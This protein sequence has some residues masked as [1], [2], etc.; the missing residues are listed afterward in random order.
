MPDSDVQATY[1]TGTVA[2]AVR[3]S[4]H[5][6]AVS[7]ELQDA[8][9]RFEDLLSE[10]PDDAQSV[11]MQT[12]WLEDAKGRYEQRKR[13][14]ADLSQRLLALD[15]DV[16]K[17]H[18]SVAALQ[19]SLAQLKQEQLA[20][21]ASAVGELRAAIYTLQQW[22]GSYVE[23]NVVVSPPD[24]GVLDKRLEELKLYVRGPLHEAIDNLVVACAKVEVSEAKRLLVG[25]DNDHHHFFSQGRRSDLHDSERVAKQRERDVRDQHKELAREL[26]RMAK[27][28]NE[29]ERQKIKEEEVGR[30]GD[31][32]CSFV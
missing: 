17:H 8:L 12:Q 5:A 21:I 1:L 16:A 26:K 4:T 9:A 30:S 32:A 14:M 20:E 22:G 7:A 31:S 27:A 19:K 18:E 10:S 28:Q 15:K 13:M 29:A 25:V 6:C 3:C 24:I 11:D 2:A 23:H